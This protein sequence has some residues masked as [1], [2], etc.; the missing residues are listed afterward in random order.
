VLSAQEFVITHGVRRWEGHRKTI[1][2]TTYFIDLSLVTSE[3]RLYTRNIN[4]KA[5]INNAGSA[6]VR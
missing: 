3:D 6:D 2:L 5:F 1:F 4:Y